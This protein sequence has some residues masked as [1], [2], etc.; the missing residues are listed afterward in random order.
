MAPSG[1]PPLLALAFKVRT[2]DG[3]TGEFEQLRE[4]FSALSLFRISLGREE[5]RRREILRDLV[6]DAG[7]MHNWISASLSLPNLTSTFPRERHSCHESVA[8]PSFL[9]CATES[10]RC[11]RI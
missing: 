3:E 5:L 4:E 6:D 10:S 1:L 2:T 8:A 11:V 7:G 9:D